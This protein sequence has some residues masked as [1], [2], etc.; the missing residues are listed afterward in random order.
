MVPAVNVSPDRQ[1][2]LPMNLEANPRCYPS[3]SW[4][5]LFPHE[6]LAQ[7]FSL[8]RYHLNGS[9]IL[10]RSFHVET[11]KGEHTE[12]DD[13]GHDD[14]DDDEG[15]NSA[16]DIDPQPTADVENHGPE[17]EDETDEANDVQL[18]EG[19]DSDDEDRE[20]PSDVA[21]VPMADML[22]ARFESENVRFESP[23]PLTNCELTIW[24]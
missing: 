24:R 18:E 3:Q 8:E 22:N 9:R 20:D 19:E 17:P 13:D 11:W 5:D 12:E 16:M 23:S 21:M 10:S 6:K 7:H 1:L 15:E 4:P 2:C 14:A